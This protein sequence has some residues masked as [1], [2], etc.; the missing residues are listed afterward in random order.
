MKK[1]IYVFG[2]V[3]GDRAKCSCV[4]T[5]DKVVVADEVYDY[6][7]KA[8]SITSLG[9]LA[10]SSILKK[11]EERTDIVCNFPYIHESIK[12]NYVKKW[13]FSGWKT[14]RGE[15]LHKELWQEIHKQIKKKK[16]RLM[17]SDKEF[18]KIF[19]TGL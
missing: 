8:D 1:I 12:K 16:I 19:T 6:S 9:L 2:K 13:D 14:I 17:L 7:G 10:L 11:C 18:S 3:E 15:V 4:E 5:L